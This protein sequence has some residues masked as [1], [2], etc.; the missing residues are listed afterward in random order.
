MQVPG[1]VPFYC[2]IVCDITP[3]IVESAENYGLTKTP[4]EAGFFGFN[5]N[6]RG[7]VEVL[8]F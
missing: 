5:M 8:S 1:H 6:L 4:D 2:Y 7:Y 3:K